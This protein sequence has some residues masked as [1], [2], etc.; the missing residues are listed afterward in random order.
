MKLAWEIAKSVLKNVKGLL[1]LVGMPFLF[2]MLISRGCNEMARPPQ[3]GPLS[4]GLEHFVR[5]YHGERWLTVDGKWDCTDAWVSP[6]PSSEYNDYTNVFVPVVPQS[7]QP[8]AA[9]HVIAVFDAPSKLDAQAWPAAHAGHGGPVTGTVAPDGVWNYHKMFPNLVVTDPIAFI[10]VG[11]TPS[12]GDGK[13]DL[14]FGIGIAILWTSVVVF[15]ALGICRRV[16]SMHTEKHL[17]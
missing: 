11:Q 8:G 14:W 15:L 17:V 4:V 13:F 3:S 9:V 16:R 1:F 2:W 7:W 10:Y 12:P 5:D 6:V